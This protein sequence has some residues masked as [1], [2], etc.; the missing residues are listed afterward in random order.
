MGISVDLI[1]VLCISSDDSKLHI[2]K[3]IPKNI[4]ENYHFDRY[5]KD[6]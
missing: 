6:M 5:E 3:K 1:L 4:S 2:I